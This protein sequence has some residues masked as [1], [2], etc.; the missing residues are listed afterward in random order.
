MWLPSSTFGSC[1]DSPKHGYRG[2]GQFTE[3]QRSGLCTFFNP[4]GGCLRGH[5]D[6]AGTLARG[7]AL[8]LYP[9]GEHVLVGDWEGGVMKQAQC[10]VRDFAF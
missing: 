1:Q 9:D 4:D 3:G 8:Y 10:Y 2:T 5:V 6:D 7:P